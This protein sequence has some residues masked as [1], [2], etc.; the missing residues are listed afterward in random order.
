MRRGLRL[1]GLAL[2][3]L[4]GACQ[5][6]APPPPNP[7]SIPLEPSP[8]VLPPEPPGGGY[9][10]EYAPPVATRL[11]T[12]PSLQVPG[13][14]GAIALLAIPASPGSDPEARSRLIRICQAYVTSLPDSV[15]TTRVDSD[16]PQMVTV[17]PRTDVATVLSVG[18]PSTSAAALAVCNPA[19]DRYSYPAAALWLSRLP[20]SSRF[21]PGRRGP[22]L[23]AWAPRS[24]LGVRG[25]PILTMDLSN[26]SSS[27]DIATAMQLWRDKVENRPDQWRSGWNLTQWQLYAAQQLDSYGAQILAAIKMIPWLDG[28]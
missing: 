24:S 22:F 27:A 6:V 16:A 1:P 25:A 2:L 28:D 14:F 26:F 12:S 13:N 3:L 18:S 21:P 11:F 8:I 9:A 4:V 7:V 23:L 17:W 19:V 15:Q 20:A 10:N 5:L